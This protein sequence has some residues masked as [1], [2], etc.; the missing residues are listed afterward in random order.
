ME[1]RGRQSSE[2][3]SGLRKEALLKLSGI[4][5]VN[6]LPADGGRV[7]GGGASGWLGAALPMSTT[8]AF[9]IHFFS[10]S[11]IGRIRDLIPVFREL[12]DG[13]EAGEALLLK[14]A[15]AR[16]NGCEATPPHTR[17]VRIV[18]AQRAGVS[19]RSNGRRSQTRPGFAQAILGGWGW[20][21]EEVH[22][23]R[24]PNAVRVWLA[25]WALSFGVVVII[26]SIT[27]VQPALSDP[28]TATR[29]FVAYLPILAVWW[30]DVVGIFTIGTIILLWRKSWSRQ[31]A[32]LALVI[33]AV[34]RQALLV[35]LLA[36][37]FS[38]RVVLCWRGGQYFDYDE[39]RY[40]SS[41]THLFFLLARGDLAGALD[42]LLESPL[43]AGFLVVGLVPAFFHLPAAFLAGASIADMQVSSGEWVAAAV[44]SLSSIAVIGL[45]YALS[46]RAGGS[47]T[48]AT[49]AAALAA[50]S[51]A[52]FF[53]SRHLL[54][55][56][57]SLA[58]A[59]A[60]L[61][62]GLGERKD[63]LDAVAAGLVASA[64]FLTYNGSWTLLP[65]LALA[66]AA[67][68]ASLPRALARMGAFGV[69]VGIAPIGFVAL[70]RMRGIPTLETW[71]QLSR[72]ATNGEF[73]SGAS[74]P[75]AFLW[76]AEHALLAIWLL[77]L[78][79]AIWQARATRGAGRRA[80]LWS[81][82]GAGLYLLLILGSNVLERFVVYDRTARLLVPFLCLASAVGIAPLV[83]RA[84]LQVRC[85][86]I[87]ILII[88][89]GLNFGEALSERF[90]RDIAQWAVRTLGPGQVQFQTTL[91]EAQPVTTLF[92]P[93]IESAPTARY[94]LVNPTDIWAEDE[95]GKAALGAVPLRLRP[96]GNVLLRLPHPRQ[97]PLHQYHGYTTGFRE[98][99]RSEDI[100]VSLVDTMPRLGSPLR[101]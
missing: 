65:M 79:A 26:G 78:A 27:L 55:Y 39:I 100:S 94:V 8:P 76:H 62:I 1:I 7:G 66:S 12:A 42:A 23:M 98:W 43:H 21:R 96:T 86:L 77:G 54:P 30:W 35:A 80:L 9:A 48:E 92:L 13:E 14:F 16:F 70:G 87:L 81:G 61:W 44:L 29:L 33:R 93:P 28:Y 6:G 41:T 73:S 2:L 68:A 69:A 58:L 71:I 83:A 84:N 64:S 85:A 97:R 101:P 4:A 32:C 52:L 31:Q 5:H 88:Q 72:Q 91:G 57:A 38:V 67:G 49:I 19:C 60:A 50:S 56:D 15:G 25:I 46:L 18:T 34:R 17:V 53:F 47:K 99:L 74:L 20:A 24:I 45:V 10:K 75:W 59:L 90:P 11:A 22:L 51:N 36:V 95:D 82:M 89:T 40:G 37:S 63:V 3:L